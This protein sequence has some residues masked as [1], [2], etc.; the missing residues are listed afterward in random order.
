M[1]ELRLR[2]T[3]ADRGVDIQFSVAAGE[4]LA[5]LG[6]NG[7]GKSTAL[8]VIAGLV[9][10][11]KGLV[12]LGDRA[13]TDTAAGGGVPTPER[14]VGLP[15]RAPLLFPHMS[16]ADNVAFGPRSRRGMLAGA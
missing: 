12:R 6:P 16:V 5:V 11:D 10:P 7:A 13:L 2:A 4:V 1:S 9:R 3:V 14:G 15:R 8:H